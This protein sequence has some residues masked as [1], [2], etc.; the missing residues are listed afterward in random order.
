[1]NTLTISGLSR[2]DG[3][4]YTCIASNQFGSA[5]LRVHLS[6]FGECERVK[7][8]SDRNR[9]FYTAIILNDHLGL[10]RN[11]SP[12]T[13]ANS[14]WWMILLTLLTKKLL[15]RQICVYSYL[16]EN[17]V[18]KI[19]EL[20]LHCTIN[21]WDVV[22]LQSHRSPPAQSSCQMSTPGL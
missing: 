16:S 20:F 6:V 2:Q 17:A 7:I 19:Y 14:S 22:V 15:L 4:E 21:L 5:S 13:F 11:S 9:S 3:G 12:N 1:M 8:F 18:L 10:Q